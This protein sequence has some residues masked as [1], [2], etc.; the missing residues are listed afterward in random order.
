VRRA[1]HAVEG[2][3]NLDGRE[4]AVDDRFQM[5]ERDRSVHG[6]EHFARADVDSLHADA[7]HQNS[8]R[9]DF[10]G[11]TG[12]HADQADRSAGPNRSKR[13][14]ERS[15]AAEF[16]DVID[17]HAAGQFAGFLF[18]RRSRLVVDSLRGAE[19]AGAGEFVVP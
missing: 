9:V 10:A 3:A 18:P 7:F 5:V 6:L 13:L 4:D 1:F 8:D 17:A 12:Q 15:R 14:G 16:D 19:F 2:V 11:A